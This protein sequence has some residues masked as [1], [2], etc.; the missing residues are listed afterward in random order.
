MAEHPEPTEITI[1]NNLRWLKT[2]SSF[3]IDD[4]TTVVPV[5]AGYALTYSLRGTAGVIDLTSSVSG[6]DYLVSV[7]AATTATWVDG[8]YSWQAYLTLT[9][10]RYNAGSGS[11]TLMPNFATSSNI[12]S[13]S[14]ARKILDAIIAT[15]EGRA[16]SSM[17][18]Y[19]YSGKSVSKMSHQELQDSHDHWL[20]KVIVEERNEKVAKGLDSGRNVYVRF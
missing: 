7:L 8:F 9:T 12:D 5:T 16:T 11:I 20:I 4:N 13:R 10:S 18:S 6:S 2:I 14:Y 15:M 17:S 3:D 19:S 1:G